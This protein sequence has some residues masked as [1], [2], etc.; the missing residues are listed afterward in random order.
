[1]THHASIETELVDPIVL[2]V[3][4]YGGGP[5]TPRGSVADIVTVNGAPAALV[6][7]VRLYRETGG[8]YVAEGW[9]VKGTGAYRFDDLELGQRYIPVALDHTGT[10]KPVAAGPLEP[11]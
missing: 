7:R 3:R 6:Y 5:S 2:R 1:M 11:A 9:S 8:G 4:D 10:H